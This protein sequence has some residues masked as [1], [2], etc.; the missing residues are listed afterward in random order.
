MD[1]MAKAG[2]LGAAL[3]LVLVL[4]TLPRYRDRPPPAPL[5]AQAQEWVQQDP[6]E[7]PDTR[8]S[9]LRMPAGNNAE[10]WLGRVARAD[11]WPL[12]AGNRVPGVNT[13][14]LADDEHAWLESL[15]EASRAAAARFLE[16]NGSAYAFDNR[17]VHAWLLDHG[18][19]AL[20][21]VAAFEESN[22]RDACN[23]IQCVNGKVA[24]LIAD[25][26]I[27]R[28]EQMVPA[29][30]FDLRQPA[31]P[32]AGMNEAERIALG[33]SMVEARAYISHARFKGSMLYAAY[34]EE[35]LERAMGQPDRAA[36]ARALIAGC[37]DRRMYS[38]VDWQD[39]ANARHMIGLL[40]YGPTM[41]GKR[42][43]LPGFPWG[44]GE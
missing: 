10:L 16:R 32:S 19:P 28:I 11:D 9:E 33:R 38:V 2:I 42:P 22:L 43:G 1:R 7:P 6:T 8:G 13:A 25:E 34:L 17:S 40:P 30:V 29:W 20:E 4:V 35:R 39:V 27:A 24:A 44:V 15:P 26:T 21:E 37:G 3:V 5:P 36:S 41:C 12:P 18:F 31:S 23:E 14:T